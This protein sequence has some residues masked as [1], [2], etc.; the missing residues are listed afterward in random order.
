MTRPLRCL[1][2]DDEL[3]A[4]H[5]MQ[6]LLLLQDDVIVVGF[7]SDA[8]TALAIVG[9]GEVD[10]VF[11]D[12]HMPGLPGIEA[13][14]RLPEGDHRPAVVFARNITDEDNVLGVVDFN[15]NTAFVND[16]RIIGVMFGIYPAIRAAQMDPIDALRHE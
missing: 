3:L 16:P 1:I 9:A 14:E 2:V 6:R 13:A 8:D 7:C 10:V 5:R 12:I 15:N 11:L 4:R